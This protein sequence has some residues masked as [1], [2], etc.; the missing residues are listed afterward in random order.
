M[1][2]L[3]TPFIKGPMLLSGV[4]METVT[5]P[6]SDANDESLALPGCASAAFKSRLSASTQRSRN[7]RA[8]RELVFFYTALYTSSSGSG[9]AA[10]LRGDR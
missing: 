5:D 6:W 2:G 4:L 7:M 8:G 10:S 3:Y 9:G 1:Y